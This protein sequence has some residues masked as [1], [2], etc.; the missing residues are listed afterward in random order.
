MGHSQSATCKT[1][2]GHALHPD[3]RRLAYG[4]LVA[5]AA[6]LDAARR[7]GA[8]QGASRVP[9]HRPAAR[10]VDAE[11][12]VTGRARYGIDV[13]EPEARTAVMLRCPYFDGDIAQLDDSAARAVPGVRAV[14]VVP[15]PKPGEPITANL[16]TGVAVVADDTWSALKGRKAL[17]VEWTR[18]P[19][20]AESSAALDAQC[21]ELL[22]KTG[23]V[24]RNDG[25]FDAAA[26]AAAKVVKARYRMPFVS[27]A[28]LEAPCA[29]VHVQADRA[30]VVAPLQQPGGASRAVNTVTG[31][32]R[33]AISVEMTRV[34][35]GFGRR[36]TN[37]FVAEAALVSKATGWP[38]KLVWTRDG[39]PAARLLPAVRP[40]RT[41]RDARRR[42]AAS[43]AGRIASRARR[44]TTG[45]RA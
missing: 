9:H 42:R 16:A 43:P 38:I 24:V 12:I 37:D 13:Y 6:K 17:K 45:A 1:E 2:A 29:F 8:A 10:V 3:G 31:I 5:A 21:A 15:G 26:R 36:L 28:P 25:D 35:G 32:P 34:G 18:G 19:F 44:S 39:R 4:A 20:A 30:R 23:Q 41:D 7:A 33:A 40:P 11:E 22:A 27:H 14:V